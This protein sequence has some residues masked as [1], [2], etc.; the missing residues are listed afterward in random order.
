MGMA[1][2]LI[3]TLNFVNPA[4]SPAQML[5]FHQEKLIYAGKALPCIWGSTPAREFHTKFVLDYA[6]AAT[7]LPQVIAQ[8]IK[9]AHRNRTR[10]AIIKFFTN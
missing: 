9:K 5:R 10:Y 1:L 2:S 6:V 3:F 4:R 7:V 8:V